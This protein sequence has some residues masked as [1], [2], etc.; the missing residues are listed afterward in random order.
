MAA[1]LCG[2]ITAILLAGVLL[3]VGMGIM[4]IKPQFGAIPP[5]KIFVFPSGTKVTPVGFHRTPVFPDGSVLQKYAL[6]GLRFPVFPDR[7]VIIPENTVIIQVIQGIFPS[8]I[9][10]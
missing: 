2:V 9:V 1:G 3:F 8:E 7:K 4:S 10:R 5:A 6:Y